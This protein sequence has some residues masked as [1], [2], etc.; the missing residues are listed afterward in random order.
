MAFLPSEFLV[1]WVLL[2][3]LQVPH[4]TEPGFEVLP[5]VYPGIRDSLLFW[6][7]GLVTKWI[8]CNLS[9]LG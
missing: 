2:S 3:R 1:G 4:P 9:V 6:F 5:N 8:A 7:M